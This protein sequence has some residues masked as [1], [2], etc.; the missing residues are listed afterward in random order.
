MI[1]ML[2]KIDIF[3]LNASS[4]QFLS[5]FSLYNNDLLLKHLGI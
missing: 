5:W 1:S 2:V 3:L 4:W